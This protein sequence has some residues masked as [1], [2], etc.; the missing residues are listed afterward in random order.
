MKPIKSLL[1]ISTAMLLAGCQNINL[2]NISNTNN[3]GGSTTGTQPGTTDTGSGTGTGAG[4]GTGTGTGAGSGTTTKSTKYTILVY[5]CGSNLESQNSLATGN[6]EEMCSVNLK[7]DI[8]LIVETGGASKWDAKYGISASELGRWK[9]E[10]NTLNK[11][12]SKTK[13]NMGL[14]NTL[15][16]FV[17]WGI[18]TYPAEKTALVFWNHGGA[19]SGVCAD[20]N[21]SNDALLNS[22]VKTALTNSLGSKK[23]EWIGYDTCL[24]QVQDVAEF[25]SQFANYMVASQETEPGEG[26]DWDVWLNALNNNVN[27]STSSLLST[28][29]DSYVQKVEDGNKEY[30]DQ[31]EELAN[32]LETNPTALQEAGWE[33]ENY[34]GTYYLID[35]DDWYTA[36]DLRDMA[37]EYKDNDAT[38]SVL[39]LSKMG[40]YK[41]AFESMASKLQAKSL[42]SSAARN[43]Y[44]D[45]ETYAGSSSSSYKCYDVDDVL[46]TIQ[47]SYSDVGA[48][49]VLTKLNELIIHNK[50]GNVHANSC[51]LSVFCGTASSSETNFTNWQ[52][53]I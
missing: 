30:V 40:T 17:S 8:N 49:D 12:G 2:S 37:N 26:W 18:E 29:A 33:V 21:Y 19:M 52:A 38:C 13:A 34:Y 16:E 3:Q 46:N 4:T 6:L 43:L 20:E 5:M 53:V 50:V 41:T 22:E 9:V 28:V 36:D 44:K 39:D 1:L 10:N 51:G 27:I 15:K 7:S 45:A 14:S 25:N 11:V 23:F 47:S 32:L 35:E 31:L 42:S 48:S 24:M